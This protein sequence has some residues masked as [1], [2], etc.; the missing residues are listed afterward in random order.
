MK[1][2]DFHIFIVYLTTWLNF[3]KSYI[4][5]ANFFGNQIYVNVK[6]LEEYRFSMKL[7][8]PHKN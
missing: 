7:L 3:Y 1:V 4:F 8:S 5:S 2:V 6:T